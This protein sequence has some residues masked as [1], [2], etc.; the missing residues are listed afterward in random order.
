M[1]LR[2]RDTAM[3][4]NGAAEATPV[5]VKKSK[6][7]KDK[8][9]K[10]RKDVTY[11]DLPTEVEDS[12]GTIPLAEAGLSNGEEEDLPKKKKKSKKA[13][14][15]QS[16]TSTVEEIAPAQPEIVTRRSQRIQSASVEPEDIS[17]PSAAPRKMKKSQIEAMK[18]QAELDEI[19][20]IPEDDCAATPNPKPTT[21]PRSFSNTIEPQ[22]FT[23][24]S[25]KPSSKVRGKRKA[26]DDGENGSSKKRT[27]KDKAAGTPPLTAFGFGSSRKEKS[28]ANLASTAER[29]YAELG[30]ESETEQQVIAP[31]L[32]EDVRIKLTRLAASWQQ[33]VHSS[34]FQSVDPYQ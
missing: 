1:E 12:N 6:Q 10:K 30:S 22:K 29:L 28:P 8:S 21:P 15:R 27:R 25:T 31:Y 24:T 16:Q 17:T 18:Q 5:T 3:D 32:D 19:Y 34:T 33:A 9:V 13:S 23:E 4:M 2:D 20:A 7:G 11:P 26:S 14:K